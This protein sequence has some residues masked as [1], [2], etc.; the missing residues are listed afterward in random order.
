MPTPMPTPVWSPCFPDFAPEPPSARPPR[1]V[2]LAAIE[3]VAEAWRVPMEGCGRI[4][5]SSHGVVALRP[6]G[7][8]VAFGSGGEPLPAPPLWGMCAE[9]DADGGRIVG[10]MEDGMPVVASLGRTDKP[11]RLALHF[12][13][14]RDVHELLALRSLRM[15]VAWAR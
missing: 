15:Q 3:H 6:A 2:P 14:G 9:F 12:M 10:V 13:G 1:E 5:A 8:C 7:P 4:I 11:A